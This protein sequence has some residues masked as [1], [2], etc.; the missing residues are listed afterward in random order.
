MKEE[1]KVRMIGKDNNLSSIVIAIMPNEKTINNVMFYN[2]SM[3]SS[4]TINHFQP[5]TEY[6]REL[7]GLYKEYHLNGISVG[8]PQQNILLKNANITNYDDAIDYLTKEGLYS[9]DIEKYKNDYVFDGSV[10][11]GK[12]HYNKGFVYKKIK[13]NIVQKIID[14]SNK[15]NEEYYEMVKEIGNQKAITRHGEKTYNL[16]DKEI[17]LC[18]HLDITE[19]EFK[20]FVKELEDGQYNY[21]RYINRVLNEKEKEAILKKEID[22]LISNGFA[23]TFVNRFGFERYIKNLRVGDIICCFD[24]NEYRYKIGDKTYY[25][26]N[27]DE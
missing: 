4:I 3:H 16:S 26:Y 12:Y 10:I 23:D 7:I 18:R 21:L 27:I 24:T 9:E 6:Q 22:N 20:A 13:D 14:I 11:D 19:D 1:I 8:T 15:V 17:A 25:V 2:D 5:A